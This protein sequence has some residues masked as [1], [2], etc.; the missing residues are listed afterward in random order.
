MTKFNLGGPSY[1]HLETDPLSVDLTTSLTVLDINNAIRG[2][3]F[4]HDSSG[5]IYILYFF[6]F[7]TEIH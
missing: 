4:S 3:A 2:M 1:K 6:Y 5:A 7:S